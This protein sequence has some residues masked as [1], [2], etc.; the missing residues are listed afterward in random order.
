M[1]VCKGTEASLGLGASRAVAAAAAVAV[2]AKVS[3]PGIALI[4][5]AG[6]SCTE[7]HL[8]HHKTCSCT[9]RIC[10]FVAPERV[11]TA[12]VV[13]CLCCQLHASTAFAQARSTVPQARRALC[14][15]RKIWHFRVRMAVETFAPILASSCVCVLCD[16]C[17]AALA[18]QLLACSLD[19]LLEV[20]AAM[21]SRRR[22]RSEFEDDDAA[23]SSG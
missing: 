18:Q 11:A 9:H 8:S 16:R 14:S 7:V 3:C 17:A 2:D 6:R 12:S 19:S 4:K 10:M 20:L 23:D 13:L 15:Q 22:G 21:T 1:Q 5:H